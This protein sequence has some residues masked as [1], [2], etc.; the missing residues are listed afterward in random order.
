MWLEAW[1]RG[2]KY[3]Y[4]CLDDEQYSSG[5][6]YMVVCRATKRESLS[7]EERRKKRAMLSGSLLTFSVCSGSLYVMK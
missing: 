2:Y 7:K 3:L 6:R 1:L 4:A 5:V